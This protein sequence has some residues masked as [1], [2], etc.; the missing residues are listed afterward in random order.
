MMSPKGIFTR[1]PKGVIAVTALVVSLVGFGWTLGGYFQGDDFGYVGRFYE[2]PF[3]QWPKLFVA[4]WA[5]DMW[6]FQ[7]REL[8]PVTA[9]SFMV[10]G[11]VWGGNATGFRV[12]NLFF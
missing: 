7:L 10:D 2:Y 11:R 1:W 6:G 4:S 5:G 8:R 12:T 9:L 3:A